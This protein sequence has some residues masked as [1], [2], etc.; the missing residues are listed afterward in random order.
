MHAW[1][2][3]GIP[4][5][6]LCGAWLHATPGGGVHGG[7]PAPPPPWYN[8]HGACPALSPPIFSARPRRMDQAY[9][10]SA[11]P[12]S[13]ASPGWW[14]GVG[15]TW[16]TLW[17][18]EMPGQRWTRLHNP[19]F[20]SWTC[21]PGPDGGP[22]KLPWLV[23]AKIGGQAAWHPPTTS[24]P[25]GHRPSLVS[26]GVTDHEAYIGSLGTSYQV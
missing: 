18:A 24:T 7:V 3:W 2:L 5:C 17:S 8:M 11:L 21:S 22:D 20:M 23:S 10:A 15:V 6:M 13:V 12:S 19:D 16:T 9:R 26:S 4:Q 1:H 25:P 14:M